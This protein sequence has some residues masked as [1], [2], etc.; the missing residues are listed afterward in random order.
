[1]DEGTDERDEIDRNE[2]KRSKIKSKI[3]QSCKQL[4]EE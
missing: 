4:N 2:E 1:M 3:R